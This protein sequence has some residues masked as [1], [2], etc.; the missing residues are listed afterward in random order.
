MSSILEPTD[1]DFNKL[2]QTLTARVENPVHFNRLFTALPHL[3]REQ[4]R[5][6]LD[7]FVYYNLTVIDYYNATSHYTPTPMA[8]KLGKETTYIKYR[9]EQESLFERRREKEELEYQNL[10]QSI[11]L[12][13]WQFWFMIIGAGGGLIAFLVM[14]YQFIFGQNGFINDIFK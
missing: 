12:S 9:Y 6:M 1:A 14:L 5:I 2:F 10:K 8:L 7:E 13:R 11:R 4:V 3:D